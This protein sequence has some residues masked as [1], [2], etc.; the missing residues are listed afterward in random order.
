MQP[1]GAIE[2]IKETYQSFVETSF[3]LADEDL[4]QAFR[5]LVKE[6]HLL[7]QDPFVSLSRPFTIG[8]TLEQLARERTLGNEIVAD[9]SSRSPHWKFAELHAHQH[10]SI[11]RLSS[12]HQPT[13]NTLIATGTGSGKTEAFLIPII[14]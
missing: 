3:P 4:K 5:G 13:Q 8:A 14:D 7:W 10:Q 12:H 2:K 9:V 1:F 6:K 11:L